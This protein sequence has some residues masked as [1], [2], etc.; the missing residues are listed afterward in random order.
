[1]VFIPPVGSELRIAS[2]WTFQVQVEARNIAFLRALGIEVCGKKLQ[3]GAES[4]TVTLPA[5]STVTVMRYMLRNGEFSVDSRVA[6]STV[7]NGR[8]FLFWVGLPD[9]NKIK[10]AKKPLP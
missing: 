7:I 2:D 5:G 10:L 8:S 4:K 1:M 6:L 3:F 9:A